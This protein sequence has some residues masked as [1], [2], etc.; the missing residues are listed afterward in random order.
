MSRPAVPS[1][2]PLSSVVDP[3]ARAVLQAMVD[4]QRIRNG[5]VG[6]G[7]EKFLTVADLAQGISGSWTSSS[8]G[9]ASVSTPAAQSVANVL[10]KLSDKIMQSR[11]WKLLDERIAWIATPEW[12]NKKFDTSIVAEQTIRSDKDGELAQQITTAFTNLNGNL[13]GVR[14]EIT[15]QS[16]ATSA[17]A[18]RVTTVVSD[19]N[20]SLGLVQQKLNS[21]TDQAGSTASSV[22]QL[23]TRVSGV[24]V[25]AK[26]S[27]SLAASVEGAVRGTKVI[28]FDL[29]GYIAGTCLTVDQLL[30]KPPT[31]VFVI[32]AD[33]FAVGAPGS[34]TVVPFF[35]QDGVTYIKTAMIA[36]LSVDTLKLGNE[37]ITTE[38]ITNG[39]VTVSAG[40]SGTYSC[41]VWLNTDVA[42][43]Y[44]VIATFTQGGER[45]GEA[46]DLIVDG[47]T[48]QRGT[49]IGGT[50][51]AMSTLVSLAPGT[52]QF[53]INAP[54]AAGGG[55]CGITVMGAKK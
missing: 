40:S 14:E 37:V 12:F 54:Y 4:G 44:M 31:S 39:A 24:E 38:K 5:D 10:Q 45:D 15:A 52:H 34:Q 29:N 1:I 6:D 18:Q 11:A 36:D 2:P 41:A 22:T 25:T 48:R 7:D 21:T 16:N 47:V 27:L 49:P 26:E 50:E 9:K 20:G 35:V 51:G 3:N 42:T 33:T 55:S 13:A 53:S 30:G 19:F 8:S 28:A 46:W 17:L 23:Q 32:R 43:T